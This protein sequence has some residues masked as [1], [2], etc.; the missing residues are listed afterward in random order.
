MVAEDADVRNQSLGFKWI[1][2]WNTARPSD[3]NSKMQSLPV[4][5]VVANAPTSRNV[6]FD[7]ETHQ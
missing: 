4:E 3:I 2:R 7:K 6:S 5:L 1:A